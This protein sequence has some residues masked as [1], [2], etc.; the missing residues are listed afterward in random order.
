MS[1]LFVSGL[2]VAAITVVAC[3][4][5]TTAPASQLAISLASAYSITPAGFSELST[6][7]AADASA[8]AFTFGTDSHGPGGG[9][10]GGFGGPGDG[11]GFGIGL[12]GGG[13]GGAF[14][15]DGIG[16]DYFRPDSSCTFSSATG[17]VTCGPTTHNGI[18]VTRVSKYTTTAGV[19]QSKRDS[20]TNTVTA[21]ITVTG[22]ATR[23]D[24]STSTVSEKSNQTVTGLAVGS[25]QR[26][27][28]GTSSGTEA[29]TGTSPQGAFTSSRVVGDT[30]T[31]VIVPV[32]TTANP[33]PYPTAGAVIRA[34]SATVT[35]TGQA[36][37]TSKRREVVTYD[38]TAT[39]KVVITV[40]GTTQSCTLPLPHGRLTCT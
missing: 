37:T 19:A 14:F 29:T 11:P 6:S 15:G 25:T 24:S 28:N 5:D 8:G 34:M 18:T 32:E 26:T 13:L 3:S 33:H 39:A 17:Q 23:R 10:H 4:R 27:V 21:A 7:Y 40:D 20:T 30:V 35:I 22:T 9:R 2:A 38:G 1:R 16:H 12:M 36:A 31:G